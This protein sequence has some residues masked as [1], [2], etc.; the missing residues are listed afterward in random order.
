MKDFKEIPLHIKKRKGH[1][2]WQINL[3]T[4]EIS[5]IAHSEEVFTEENHWYCSALNKE[6]AFR[7]FNLMAKQAIHHHHDRVQNN[8]QS[9]G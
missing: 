6:N 9:G 7:K 4:Q 1:S 3:R 8:R 5:T 2:L